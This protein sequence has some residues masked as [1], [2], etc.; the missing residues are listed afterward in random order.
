MRSQ[1]HYRISAAP[2]HRRE[3]GCRDWRKRTYFICYVG[4]ILLILGP[5]GRENLLPG[6][7]SVTWSARA[8]SAWLLAV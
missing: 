7:R 5:G 2:R 1:R 8:A 4:K 6:T 3:G